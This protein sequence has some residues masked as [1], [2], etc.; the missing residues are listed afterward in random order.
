MRVGKARQRRYCRTR[1]RKSCPAS[2]QE[3][4]GGPGRNSVTAFVLVHG[5][6]QGGWIWRSVADRLRAA[7]HHVFAPT[8][9]GCAERAGALRAGI[10]NTT[11]ATEIARLM[12]Y[13]DLSDAVV[14]G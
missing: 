2:G 14:V 6:Y 5:A 10:T 1:C 9:D 11:H 13:E 12:F 3:P 8:L 4:P 7:G